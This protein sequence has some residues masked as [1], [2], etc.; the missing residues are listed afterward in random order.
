MVLMD[1]GT[2]VSAVAAPDDMAVGEEARC[3]LAD[4]RARR[5][6]SPAR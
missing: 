1:D 3:D 5:S 6:A 2:T 4:G